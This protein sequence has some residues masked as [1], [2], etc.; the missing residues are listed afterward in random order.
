ML[1][2]FF[3]GFVGFKS[4]WEFKET[5]VIKS[6]LVLFETKSTDITILFEE[7]SD[8]IFNLLFGMIT[9]EIGKKNFMAVRIFTGFSYFLFPGTGFLFSFNRD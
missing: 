5:E 6:M 3:D 4:F 1:I 8:L 2:K 7:S 9:I